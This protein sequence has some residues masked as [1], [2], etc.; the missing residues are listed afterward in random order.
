[1]KKVIFV[2]FLFIGFASMAQVGTVKTLVGDTLKGAETD[3]SPSIYLKG[4][5]T[6]SMQAIFTELG[7]TSDGTSTVEVSLDNSNWAEITAVDW[8]TWGLPSV[9]DTIVNGGNYMVTCTKTP[10]LYYRFK[11]VGTSGDTT[12]IVYKYVYK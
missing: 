10:Y 2:I 6:L 11:S 9:G 4:N 8:I 1:M 12:K 7:G 3:Y 5:Y